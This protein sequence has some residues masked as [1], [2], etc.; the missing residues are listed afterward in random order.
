M[1]GSPTGRYS[2]DPVEALTTPGPQPVGHLRRT[3]DRAAVVPEA[4]QVVVPDAPRL[5]VLP[6]DPGHEIIVAVLQDAVLPDVPRG[7][8]PRRHP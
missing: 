6:A 1:P 7:C 5:R 2:A 3:D 8:C 4:D